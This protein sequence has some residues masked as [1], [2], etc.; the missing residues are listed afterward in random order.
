MLKYCNCNPSG[1]RVQMVKESYF[2]PRV[3]DII[4]KYLCCS[5]GHTEQI[6]Y[7]EFISS[8]LF[9]EVDYV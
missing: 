4:F 3:D 7:E 8:E 6:S 9:K 2:D 5:C 1:S